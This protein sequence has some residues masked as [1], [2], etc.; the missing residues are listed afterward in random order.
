MKQAFQAGRS[1]S[2]YLIAVKEP[3][4][5]VQVSCKRCYLTFAANDEAAAAAANILDVDL[6]LAIAS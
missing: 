3:A 1:T 4:K 2:S 5:V 6:Y